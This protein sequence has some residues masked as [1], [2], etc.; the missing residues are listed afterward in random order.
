MFYLI[1]GTNFDKSQAKYHSLIDSLLLRHPEG[2]VFL[3]DNENFSEANLAELLVSQGLFYQK[4]LIGLNQLLSHK[5][6]SPIILGKLSELA[7]S[8]NVFIFLE[9]ELDPQILKKIAGQA[10]KILCFDQKPVPLK[11]TFNRYTL[12]DALISRNK[13]K[14]WLAF[15][16]AKLSGVEDFD[17]FWL[18]WSQLKLLLL[19]KTTTVKAP[20]NI[21]PY[22]FSKAKRGSENYTEEELKILAGRFLRHYHQYYFGSEAFDFHLERILLEI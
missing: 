7:E 16:Q 22:L 18:L 5:N 21:R 13:Q 8:P 4:Y 11:A 15:W 14:L 12:S 17:I 1:H 9:A 19:A 3:W 6:S 10:E 20:K 2:S